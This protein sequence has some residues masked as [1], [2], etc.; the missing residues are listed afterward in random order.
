MQNIT[1]ENYQQLNLSPETLAIRLSQQRSIYGEHSEALY[2][3]SSFLFDDAQQAYNRFTDKEGGYTYSRADNPT[4]TNF[5]NKLAVLENAES[6]VATSS[7]MSAILATMM[8]FLNAGDEIIA[9]A[10]LFSTT[11]GFFNNFLKKLNIKTHYVKM[12]DLSAWEQVIASDKDGKIKIA[13]VESPSNP[14]AEVADLQGIAEIVHNKAKNKILFLVDNC[15][16]TPILQQPLK[17]GA[18]L[19]IHS[20]TKFMDG[21]GRVLG[22]AVCGNK[23]LTNE[24]YKFIKTCGVTL[25]VFNAWVLSKGLE[26]LALRVKAQSNNAFELAKWLQNQPQIETVFYPFLETH[27][28][29]ELAKKQQLGGGALFGFVVKGGKDAAWQVVNSCKML[30]ITSNFGDV[31]TTISHPQTCSHATLTQAE[32]DL[33]NI[34]AGASRI[35]VGLENL[36]DIKNDL[37]RGLS[38]I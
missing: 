15:A 30:S 17:F 3:T 13:F 27:P 16:L 29:Y 37:L 4:I 8:A 6:C 2:L 20:A 23:E 18:D 38:K 36:D 11:M 12:T 31:K 33:A 10:S 35:G 14:M 32:F 22:G 25:P 34:S 24:I 5:T 1:P 26:T 19:V 28:Q 9:S 7:G 21:Q